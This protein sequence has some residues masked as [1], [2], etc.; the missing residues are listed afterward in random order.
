MSCES[1]TG[2]Q[3][4][5]RW[6]QTAEELEPVQ[7]GAFLAA[8]RCRSYRP[9]ELA[10]MARVLRAASPRFPDVSDRLRAAI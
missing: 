9:V 2:R 1:L 7:T 6:W 3:V 5:V 10:A 8:L 4:K